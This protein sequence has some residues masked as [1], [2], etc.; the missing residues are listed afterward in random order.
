MACRER[1]IHQREEIGTAPTRISR[2]L[3]THYRDEKNLKDVAQLRTI[4]A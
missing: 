4:R 3:L 1:D 2:A